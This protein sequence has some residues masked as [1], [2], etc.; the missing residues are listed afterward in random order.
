MT[1]PETKPSAPERSLDALLRQL[2]VA[3][4]NRARDRAEKLERKILER[5]VK[6]AAQRD[7]I[8][9]RVREL[10]ARLSEPSLSADDDTSEIVKVDLG[11][12]DPMRN[13][14]EGAGAR[15]P[16][17]RREHGPPRGGPRG[18][19]PL[20]RGAGPPEGIVYPV[21]FGTN[22]KPNASRDGFTGE[23]HDQ[24][25]YGR[26]EVFVPEAHRFGETGSGFWRRLLRFD[27]RDDRLRLQ[28]ALWLGPEAFFAEIQRTMETARASGEAPHALFYLH[29]F[30]VSFEEAAIRAAQIGFDLKVPGAT[31]FFSWPSRGN[32]TAY[33]ADA[34]SIEASERA[35]TEFLIDFTAHCGAEKVH[36][37]AHS[38]GNRGLLRAL[39]RIAATAETRGR[40]KLGQIF[41]AAPDVDRD[42][43]L[44]LAGLYPEHAERV[45]L[46]ASSRD[47]P[48][49]LSSQLH[50]A[51]RAG[52]YTPYTVA[53][54][55]DTVAVP[56]FDVDL[57]GH[58]YYAQ[59]EALLHD[60]Y[61]LMRH[62]Q[63]PKSR[64]RL[65]P[66]F[67]EGAAFWR[68]RR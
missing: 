31:A 3:V 56:N 21:W 35:I 55:I 22:R 59:A 60:L 19:R 58:S 37:V 20:S 44:D 67:E 39:Q 16:F 14:T 11:Y 66:A 45:T 5:L 64:Q 4:G 12:D 25:S 6:E 52:Y 46:Y 9:R 24:T 27:L 8:E 32:I 13:P 33:A 23:R 57:L 41:L 61:D 65:T 2:E 38:M 68:L 29:G 40:V 54:G 62:G 30:N 15:E 43:F 28:R 34:A 63:A 1:E 10:M 50:D 18:D 26:A 53:P 48:V 7:E 47:L 42:L 36:V 51:P 49:Y 17:S